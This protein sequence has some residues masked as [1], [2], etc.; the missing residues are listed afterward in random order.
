MF[1]IALDA[2]HGYNTAGKRCDDNIDPKETREWTL[3]D[4]ICDKIE[5]KL[6]GYNGYQLLRVDDTTGKTD[7][8]LETRCTKANSF[9]ANI[10][11]SIHH[12]AGIKGGSG[13]GIV[14]Y[15]WTKPD[16][17]LLEWQ[18]L[19][20]NALITKTGLKGNRSNPL[21]KSDFRVLKNTKMQ[22]LHLSKLHQ[23]EQKR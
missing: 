14:V 12:N 11:L 5:A 23:A 19:F 2:G 7:V 4:R 18:K 21:A 10:Y 20:Y 15:T 9:G 16:T 1:K 13:G 6:K 22:V 3:N 8:P 17:Q